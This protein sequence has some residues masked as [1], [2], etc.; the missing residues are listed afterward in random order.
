MSLPSGAFSHFSLG[1]RRA[2][3]VL[4]GRGANFY[5]ARHPLGMQ[6]RNKET[7]FHIIVLSSPSSRL[8]VPTP[9]PFFF[10]P[11]LLCVYL[12]ATVQDSEWW[13]KGNTDEGKNGIFRSH[14]CKFVLKQEKRSSGEERQMRNAGLMA[15]R[16]FL[17]ACLPTCCPAKVHIRGELRMRSKANKFIGGLHNSAAIPGVIVF[18]LRLSCTN[19]SLMRSCLVIMDGIDRLPLRRETGSCEQSSGRIHMYA[20]WTE[21]VMDIVGWEKASGR[22]LCGHPCGLHAVSHVCKDLSRCLAV[23]NFHERPSCHSWVAPRCPRAPAMIE[24]H[25]VEQWDPLGRH[26]RLP[27]PQTGLPLRTCSAS[28]QG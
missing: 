18:P 3:I 6:E 22:D 25:S 9:S 13:R 17:R 5:G 24:L 27:G 16:L 23:L 28:I 15:G 11:E 10:I 14:E 7:V 2:E 21:S 26:P 4:H 8:F 19:E 1:R 12:C 20:P